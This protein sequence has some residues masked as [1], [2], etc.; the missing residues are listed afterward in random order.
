M[1]EYNKKQIEMLTTQAEV[2][3]LK[4]DIAEHRTRGYL[5]Y[6][7]LAQLKLGPPKETAAD[8]L[9]ETS[10]KEEEVRND[11]LKTSI[12]TTAIY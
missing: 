7:R 3:K 1:L 4:A 5:N 8:A 11:H 9:E 6:V 12:M 10:S 2:E